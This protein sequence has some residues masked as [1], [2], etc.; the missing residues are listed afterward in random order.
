VNDQLILR[1]DF[2]TGNAS[3]DIDS[4]SSDVKF[5]Q[6]Q[7]VETR[8]QISCDILAPIVKKL[9]GMSSDEL[10]QLR[11]KTLTEPLV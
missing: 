7:I 3:I 8:A 6:Y 2:M 1:V 5:G 10:K 4:L 11:M 9:L